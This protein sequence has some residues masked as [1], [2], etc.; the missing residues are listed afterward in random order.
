MRP[1]TYY[2]GAYR[3]DAIVP[4]KEESFWLPEI[5]LDEVNSLRVDFIQN[6]IHTIYFEIGLDDETESVRYKHGEADDYGAWFVLGVGEYFTN[7]FIS[8]ER[9]TTGIFGVFSV[10]ARVVQNNVIA[11]DD[12]EDIEAPVAKES[13]LFIRANEN[14]VLNSIND[15]TLE[16]LVQI[17]FVSEGIPIGN[18]TDL[19]KIGNDAEYPLT[20]NYYLTNDIDASAT[21]TWNAGAGFAPIA[22]GS[23]IYFTGTFNGRGYSITD[24]YINRPATPSC[25]LFS[26]VGTGGGSLVPRIQ[27]VKVTGTIICNYYSGGLVAQNYDLIRDCH[28]DVNITCTD[29]NGGI[30]GL[31]GLTYSASQVVNCLS[32]GL[33][34]VLSST[35]IGGLIGYKH[36][37]AVVTDSF[38]DS[39]TSGQSDTGKGTPK[40]TAELKQQ[41]TFTNWDFEET[42]DIEEDISYPTLRIKDYFV[43]N[44]TGSI[45]LAAGDFLE[46]FIKRMSPITPGAH[47]HQCVLNYTVDAEEIED[48]LAGVQLVSNTEYD[49]YQM[50]VAL[51]TDPS[52]LPIIEGDLLGAIETFPTDFPIDP[53]DLE[54]GSLYIKARVTVTN[55]YGVESQNKY[56]DLYIE[57]DE[58]EIIEDI[59]ICLPVIDL[60][61]PQ[62]GGQIRVTLSYTDD[63]EK[64][65]PYSI[66]VETQTSAGEDSNK[67]VTQL[68]A[69]DLT[70]EKILLV[71]P[72]PFGEVL[73]IRPIAYH[74]DG[75][76]QVGTWQYFE[77]LFDAGIGISHG[78]A[79]GSFTAASFVKQEDF[80]FSGDW[81]GIIDGL[82]SITF[83]RGSTLIEYNS[84]E[85]CEVTVTDTEKRITFNGYSISDDYTAEASSDTGKGYEI[86]GAYIY[87]T[88]LDGYA[89]PGMKRY[90]K[91]NTVG[92]IIY[93]DNEAS[94]EDVPYR[95]QTDPI[96]LVGNHVYWQVVNPYGEPRILTFFR[97]GRLGFSLNDFELTLGT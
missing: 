34:S 44:W 97:I 80:V 77:N 64:K 6:T 35:Y 10:R 78:N 48:I 13:S 73:K 60:V 1:V 93:F 83:G 4:G 45:S 42:W 43:S 22:S 94:D 46:I 72:F 85:V 24:L 86:D 2:R 69:V 12:E 58:T 39:T 75:R 66:G 89:G 21:S 15:S 53:V 68:N 28:S 62:T 29:A 90:V 56:L 91:I 57:I 88:A 84:A 71:V 37:S 20:G 95:E 92:K 27:N 87:L 74:Y 65:R 49:Q 11:S 96:A 61:E 76:T 67:T 25:G 5:V 51:D 19:Q 47:L 81:E 55:E 7:E 23:G 59:N 40:T 50:Y 32:T 38:Y 17:G 9:I 82:L 18:I 52:A 30:G 33:I 26:K 54:L 36:A 16:G 41:A 8:V 31:I 14:L 79:L 70:A 63:V 3:G